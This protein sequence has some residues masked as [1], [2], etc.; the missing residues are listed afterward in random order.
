MGRHTSSK[1]ERK[2]VGKGLDNLREEEGTYK[3]SRKLRRLREME[4]SKRTEPE[5]C[6]KALKGRQPGGGQELSLTVSGEGKKEISDCLQTGPPDGVQEIAGGG[7][8]REAV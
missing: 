6:M 3:E 8:E 7:R 1:E 5:E 2:K 4:S